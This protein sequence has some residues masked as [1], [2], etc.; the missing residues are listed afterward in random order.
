MQVLYDEIW[1]GKGKDGRM[2]WKTVAFPLNCVTGI[3]CS[4]GTNEYTARIYRCSCAVTTLPKV[5]YKGIYSIGVVFL[6]SCEVE[7]AYTII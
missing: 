4:S 7:M 1:G 3:V 5:L 6:I 2:L